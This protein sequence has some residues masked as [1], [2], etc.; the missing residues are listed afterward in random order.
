MAPEYANQDD[1]VFDRFSRRP[2]CKGSRPNFLPQES[3]MLST[4]SEFKSII[5]DYHSEI[6]DELFQN[7]QMEINKQDESVSIA[8]NM[9]RNI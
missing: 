9:L 5:D 3:I 8:G 7:E 4:D 6:S 2:A 1:D